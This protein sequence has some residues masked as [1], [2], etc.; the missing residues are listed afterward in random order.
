MLLGAEENTDIPNGAECTAYEV[1]ENT[2]YIAQ[3]EKL[4]LNIGVL[5]CLAMLTDRHPKY[6]SAPDGKLGEHRPLANNAH[7]NIKQS[8]QL[9]NNDGC[10]QAAQ[11]RKPTWGMN[12]NMHC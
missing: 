5:A 8:N 1:S 6:W 11:H 12:L 3:K 4:C 9:L 7:L 2:R 10:S